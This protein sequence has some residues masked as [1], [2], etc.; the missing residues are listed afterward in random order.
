MLY[1]CYYWVQILHMARDMDVNFGE[2]SKI[3]GVLDSQVYTKWGQLIMPQVHYR[4]A[5]IVS[6]GREVALCLAGLEKFQREIDFIELVY[7]T[8]RIIIRITQ[9]FFLLVV[10]EQFADT[11][12]IKLTM[13]VVSEDMRGDKTLQKLIRKSRDQKNMTVDRRQQLEWQ[14]LINKLGV[15]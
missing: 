14:E 7:E 12:L 15:S 4:H 8:R 6:I 2:L 9:E 10:C 13:N 1:A 11:A 5:R 3:K